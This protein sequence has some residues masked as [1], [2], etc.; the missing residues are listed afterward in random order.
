[1]RTKVTLV[2]IFLNVAL[3]FF[4][5]RFGRTGRTGAAS[6]A[7]LR[8]VFGPEAADVRSLEVPRSASRGAFQLDRR[9]ET[10][11]L[12]KPLEWPAN[13]HAARAI[14]NDLGAPEHD[15]S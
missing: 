14:V 10:W 3:F 5:S 15:A 9:R 2:L 6:L 7:A 8:L 13:P 4:I 11:F 1:M 12:T